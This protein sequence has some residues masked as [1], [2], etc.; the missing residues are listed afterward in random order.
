MT[1]TRSGNYFNIYHFGATTAAVDSMATDFDNRRT[2]TTFVAW[3]NWSD[4]DM[5][6]VWYKW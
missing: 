4:V 1:P 5:T 2:I 6:W 3:R